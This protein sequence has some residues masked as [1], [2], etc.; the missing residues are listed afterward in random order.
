LEHDFP[1]LRPDRFRQGFGREV[2]HAIDD[3]D[4]KT[5]ALARI[6]RAA[7]DL[8]S[9]GLPQAETLPIPA[10]CIEIEEVVPID[11]MRWGCGVRASSKTRP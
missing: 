7:D 6:L 4:P 1:R 9:I 3:P 10:S 8:K 5:I 11:V 2:D